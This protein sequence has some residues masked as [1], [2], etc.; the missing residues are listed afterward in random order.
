VGEDAF[1]VFDSMSDLS[2][3]RISERMLGN[4]FVLT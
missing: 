3:E 4:F 2:L 1:Y